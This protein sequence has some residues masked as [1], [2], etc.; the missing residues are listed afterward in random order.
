MAVIAVVA[1]VS[2]NGV[3][4]NDIDGLTYVYIPAGTFAMG[5]SPGDRQCDPDEKLQPGQQVPGFWLG[6]TEVTQAAWAKTKRP[7]PSNFKGDQLPVESVDWDQASDYC[8]T[9]GGRLPTAKEWEYA[10]RAGTASARYGMLD[11]I[12]WYSGNSG[13][14]PGDAHSLFIEEPVGRSAGR[15]GRLVDQSEFHRGCA[16]SRQAAKSGATAPWTK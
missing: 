16:C 14:S 5:C 6:Q 7:N 4:V 2:G 9:I 8:R 10:A 15:S 13:E 11:A 12:A 3:R 1:V